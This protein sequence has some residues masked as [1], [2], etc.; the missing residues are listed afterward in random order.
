MKGKII[1]DF[2]IEQEPEET[3]LGKFYFAR[4]KFMHSP[5]KVLVLDRKIGADSS[6][7]EKF[8]RS[9]SL[10]ARLSDPSLAKLHTISSFQDD[11]Y[12]VYA[13]DLSQEEMPLEQFL[14]SRRGRLFEETI[15]EIARQIAAALDLLHENGLYGGLNLRSVY[16]TEN[17][18][19]RL[20][21]VGIGKTAGSLAEMLAGGAAS[22]TLSKLLANQLYFMAP[23]EKTG[24]D[25]NYK[26][27]HFAFGTL[28]YF[29]LMGQFP[30]GYFPLPS[31]QFENSRF[32]W[33]LLIK[34]LISPMPARR[35]ETLSSLISEM[36][37]KELGQ[38]FK[39]IE[40]RPYFAE[41]VSIPKPKPAPSKSRVS[42]YV[43]VKETAVLKLE[44]ESV[45]QEKEPVIM[46]SKLERHEYESDPGAIFQK[47]ITIKPYKPAE[48]EMSNIE[49]V[50][51]EM[52]IIEAG[53]YMRGSN[54]G[55]RDERPRHKIYLDAFALDVQPVTN[56]QYIRF[57]E[58]MGGEKDVTNN[59]MIQ[60]KESRIKRT[61]GRLAIESGYARHPVVGVSWYGAAAYA[62]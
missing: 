56:E 43:T 42:Q 54:T 15:Y 35:R 62:K 59:D 21:N 32:N 34:S 5:H 58:A 13:G 8:E 20:Y 10:Y 57:L 17:I 11:L 27:D 38:I 46:P 61:G 52:V 49:P 40:S 24:K 7:F 44:K 25:V 53:E 37:E 45:P 28:V 6:A 22:R 14:S 50:L 18:H 2:V 4:H 47:E 12:L 9:V 60:L 23:E 3:L 55:A 41:E 39:K 36:K 51:A 30:E 31:S 33:D 29:L 1:G 16:I 48:K 26:I 19:V